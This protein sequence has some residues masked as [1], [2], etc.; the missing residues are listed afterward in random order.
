MKRKNSFF[1]CEKKRVEKSFFLL[2]KHV[3][4]YNF[5]VKTIYTNKSLVI[6]Y[7]KPE[8]KEKKKTL[9]K[10]FFAIIRIINF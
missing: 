7:E 4:F 1:A 9:E 10:C 3:E 2:V 5:D 6:T 8:K